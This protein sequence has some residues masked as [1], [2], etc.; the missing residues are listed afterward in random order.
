MFISGNSVELSNNSF[1][2]TSA[3]FGINNNPS[4]AINIS[5]NK[6]IGSILSFETYVII[7]F[8]AIKPII[9][10]NLP[11]LLNIPESIPAIANAA[12][13]IGGSF[14]IIPNTIPIVTPPV[15]P[16]KIPLFQP[17]INTI[18]IQSTFFKEYP[19]IFIGSS[20][21]IAIANN[22]LAPISSSIENT[23]FSPY[24]YI[25][26]IALTKIL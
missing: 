24:S 8:P 5:W 1:I 17:S 20:A 9:T 4:D 18:K 15:V 12:I 13:V 19:N 21:V 7:I 23:F 16:T 22:K 26:S 11:T 3:F 2:A 10:P 14:P 25:T 6:I